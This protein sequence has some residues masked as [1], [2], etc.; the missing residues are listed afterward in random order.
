MAKQR[1][2]QALAPIDVI[3]ASEME[4]LQ[5][6]NNEQLIRAWYRGESF[7]TLVGAPS[8]APIDTVYLPGPSSG[9]AIA[10]RLAAV[11]LSGPGQFC[12]YV[13]NT[14]R[15][16]PI[17]SIASV[18]NGSIDQALADWGSQEVVLRDQ[19]DII[20]QCIGST[21]TS[22]RLHW[23]EVPGEMVGKL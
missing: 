13:G 6:N 4:A 23:K 20:F 18:N 2:H 7:R 14:D 22:Y 19:H 10:L 17:A 9:Y 12:V 3:T 21:I 1:L 8:G 15:F 11:N 5:N 16:P